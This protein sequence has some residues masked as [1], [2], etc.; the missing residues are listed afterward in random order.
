MDTDAA[1]D[2]MG[3]LTLRTFCIDQAQA[4]D[5]ERL[6]LIHDRVGALTEPP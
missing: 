6:A 5:L 3:I 4:A 1:L 2:L